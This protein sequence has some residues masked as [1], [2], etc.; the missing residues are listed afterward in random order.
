MTSVFSPVNKVRNPL[1]RP[2]LWLGLSTKHKHLVSVGLNPSRIGCR[3]LAF[4]R[5]RL[6]TGSVNGELVTASERFNGTFK[7]GFRKPSLPTQ[8]REYYPVPVSVEVRNRC[9]TG[10]K[11]SRTGHNKDRFESLS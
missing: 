5:A 7:E 8:S 1:I 3:S 11:R 6:S 4:N 10:P 9:S 2:G